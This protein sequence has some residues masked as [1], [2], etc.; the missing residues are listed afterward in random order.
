MECVEFH[1]VKKTNMLRQWLRLY[2]PLQGPLDELRVL[3]CGAVPMT[4]FSIIT[5]TPA[6]H[7]TLCCES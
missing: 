7:L 6:E 5:V 1:Q 3:L 4:Q 2:L